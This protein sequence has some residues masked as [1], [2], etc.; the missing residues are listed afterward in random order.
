[1]T[2]EALLDKGRTLAIGDNAEWL[3]EDRIVLLCYPCDSNEAAPE[4]YALLFHGGIRVGVV[5]FMGSYDIHWLVFPE[6]RGRGYMSH[7]A[8]S[9]VIGL[10]EPEL[11]L[12][13]LDPYSEDFHTSKRLVELAGLSYCESEKERE[14]FR[15]QQYEERRA[16]LNAP[17]RCGSG[18]KYKNC[19]RRKDDSDEQDEIQP[20]WECDGYKSHTTATRCWKCGAD[21]DDY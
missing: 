9:G 18:E 2:N 15:R 17:C 11:K 19:C 4:K 1:V 7:F 12:T 6:Y 5:Y 10:V 20:C 16:W 13:L 3:V 14:K 21:Y 8:R